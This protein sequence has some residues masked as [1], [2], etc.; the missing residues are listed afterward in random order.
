M[1][2]TIFNFLIYFKVLCLGEMRMHVRNGARLLYLSIPI[3]FL[4]LIFDFFCRSFC[5][6][7]NNWMFHL[8][9]FKNQE[10]Q[11]GPPSHHFWIFR[12]S[13][14]PI[15][16]IKLFLTEGNS[17]SFTLKCKGFNIKDQ[18]DCLPCFKI[19]IILTR[20]TTKR[21]SWWP[22]MFKFVCQMRIKKIQV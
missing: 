7:A 10:I 4:L 2:F 17:S 16:Y 8:H 3:F 21:C 15:T 5:F 12:T 6:K 20:I 13:F 11:Q 18:K 1:L 19:P 14:L 22:G 9:S